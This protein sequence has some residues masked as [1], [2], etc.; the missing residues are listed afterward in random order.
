M[1]VVFSHCFTCN[2]DL[3]AIV[4]ISRALASEGIAMLRYDMTGLGGSEGDFSH[5]SFTTNLADLAS[6]IRFANAELGTVTGLIGHSFGGAASLA[7]AG[8]TAAVSSSDAEDRVVASAD[9]QQSDWQQEHWRLGDWSPRAVVALAAPSDTGH[10]AVLLSRMN[11]A[12]QSDGM[13]TVSIGGRVWMI[14]REMLD[15]FRSH[16]L[17]SMISRIDCPTLLVHSPSDSTVGYD[18]AVRILGLIQSSPHQKTSGKRDGKSSGSVSP[19]SPSLLTLDGA[20]HLMTSDA[21]DLVY[22]SSSVASFL[23]RYA[24][25]E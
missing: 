5:T 7:I 1:V 20:D 6:A 16:D 15:D 17:P 22:V 13:G 24:S 23:A 4:R 21:R 10:L 19:S 12:I 25:P 3:K 9:W 14:R 2:K 11:P 8:A 18:H